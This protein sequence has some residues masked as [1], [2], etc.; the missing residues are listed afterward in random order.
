MG[1]PSF[2]G[3][4]VFPLFFI[5]RSMGPQTERGGARALTLKLSG[6][7]AG[8]NSSSLWPSAPHM[9]CKFSSPPQAISALADPGYTIYQTP[10]GS[11]LTGQ[12]Q[13]MPYTRPLRGA[14]LQDR[15][16]VHHIP[17]SRGELHYRCQEQPIVRCTA[18]EDRVD[19]C[20]L[21]LPANQE[22]HRILLC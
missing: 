22:P 18:W 4:M 11:C 2:S 19:G 1:P 10:E 21:F 13:G 5:L 9:V 15:S 12:T 8:L 17:G 16:R 3:R 14:A 20:C 7:R 6:K